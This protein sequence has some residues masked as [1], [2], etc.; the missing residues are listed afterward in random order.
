MDLNVILELQAAGVDTEGAL[1]RF[2][3]NSEMYERFLKK[4]LTDRTFSQVTEAFAQGDREAALR[5]I[6]TLKGV[7]ANLGMDKLFAISAKMVDQIRADHYE[8]AAGDYPGLKDAY[9]EICGIL[10]RG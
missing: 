6:H 5:Y 7:T 3:G 1:R 2:G 10:I 4:F 9:D 8:E